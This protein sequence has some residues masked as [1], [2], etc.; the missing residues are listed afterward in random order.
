MTNKPQ[1]ENIDGIAIIGMAGKFPGAKNIREFWENLIQNKESITFFEEEELLQAGI[2]SHLLKDPY[3]VR[4][5]GVLEDI[6]LFDASFFNMTPR[7]AEVTDP[8]HRLFLESCWEAME[9]AGYNTERYPHR[10]GIFAGE[11]MNS[12]LIENVY[13]QFSGAL[14]VDS[15]QMAIGNDKDSLTTNVSYR[16]NLRGPGITIQTSSSTS[17]VAIA[18]ACQSLQN[19][20]CDMALAGGVA[21]G[22]RQKTGYLYQEGGIL[23]RDG[24]CRAFDANSSGFVTGSGVGSIVLKRLEDALEDKDQIYAVI[25]GY[26]VNNDGSKKVSYSAPSVEGQAEVVSEA[27]AYSEF[28]PESIGYIEAHGTG[29]P[30]GD[31]VEL[32]ALT[33]AY[34]MM[35]ANKNQFCAIGSVKTNIGHL[36]TAAGVAGVIKTALSLKNKKIPASLH[37]Q[38]P[39]PHID[40]ENSPF[41]V[42]TKLTDWNAEEYPRRAGVSSLGMGGTN[43]HVVIEEAP[44]RPAIKETSNSKLLLISARTETAL[45]S[46]ADNLAEFL[47][48]NPHVNMDN[49]AHTLQIGRK[50]M[51]FRS[52]IVCNNAKEAIRILNE[53]KYDMS[54]VGGTSSIKPITFMFSG[55][56]SQYV[57]MAK[58]L[59]N[60]NEVFRKTVEE[61]STIL[62]PLIGYKIEKI[63]YPETTEVKTDIENLIN[64]TIYTQPA[65]F[66]ISYA[67]ASLWIEMGIKP[68]YL[69]GHSIGEIVAACIAGVFP[70][71]DALKLVAGR[72]RLMQNMEPGAMLAVNLSEAEAYEIAGDKLSVAA[73]NSP[74]L[75]V[76]SGQIDEIDQLQNKLETNGVFYKRLRTSHAFHSIMTEPI[77]DEFRKLVNMISFNSPEFTIISNVTGRIIGKEEITDPE[78]W[79]KHMRQPVNFDAGIRGLLKKSEMIFLEVGPGDTLCSLVQE[80][81]SI[82]DKEQVLSSI[83]STLDKVND[84]EFFLN[85]AG[86]LWGN[87]FKFGDSAFYQKDEA[88]RISLPTYPFERKSYWIKAKYEHKHIIENNNNIEIPETIDT[89]ERVT[90]RL[91]T[92]EQRPRLSNEFVKA[93][94]ESHQK[95]ANIFT[96]LLGVEPI[97]IF[98]NFFELGGNSLQA[99]QLISRIQK[100]FGVSLPYQ[101]FFEEPNINNISNFIDSLTKEEDTIDSILEELEGLTEEEAAKIFIQFNTEK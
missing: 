90:L 39:N 85:T 97:G 19:F 35:G 34:R 96:D 88:S 55:Q 1:E 89:S 42:N 94:N 36:D 77:L 32:G 71:E 7:E 100:Q 51:E 14:G 59:Y 17:L 28:E 44:A 101:N 47:F 24:H 18:M 54:I 38:S 2:P 58:D 83:R 31:P 62:E 81:L 33:Q 49:V 29:T 67:I 23:S 20:Q 8:Q 52:H 13:P 70:L 60:Q 10:V 61:C 93:E 75:C 9:D 69:I 78:Y 86:K 43:A 65:I 50:E 63:I 56:G 76:I 12:Y 41:Y 79:V 98:D 6:N 91:N 26:A 45:H 37:F 92:Y 5:R 53:R 48:D 3:Y 25:K 80:Q 11:S 82:E 27:L 46:I 68:N 87:G 72:G 4:A 74:N 95:I 99:T 84:Y 57:D 16:M 64:Q 66:T 22:A 21:V 30:M 40:I 73:I 15:L